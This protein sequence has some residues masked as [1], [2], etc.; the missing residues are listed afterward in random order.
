MPNRSRVGLA[1]L[2]NDLAPGLR[3]LV[4]PVADLHLAG[5]QVLMDEGLVV[6]RPRWG[7]FVAERP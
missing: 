7:I 6:S 5:V 3:A 2:L 1:A 4:I